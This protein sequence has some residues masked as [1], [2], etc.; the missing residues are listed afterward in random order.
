MTPDPLRWIPGLRGRLEGN[1]AGVQARAGRT[2]DRGGAAVRAEGAGVRGGRAVRADVAEA[3]RGGAVRARV[4]ARRRNARAEPHRE[5]LA[6][7]ALPA[8]THGRGE[9]LPVGGALAAAVRLA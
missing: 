8:P 1:G 6:V 7:R 2:R 9:T 5:P 3:R 4:A